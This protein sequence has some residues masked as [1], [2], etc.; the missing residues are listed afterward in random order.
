MIAEHYPLT[1]LPRLSRLFLDFCGG[2]ARSFYDV[3]ADVKRRSTNTD[4]AELVAMLSEQNPTATDSLAALREGADAVVTGQQVGLFGGPLFTIF[5]AATAIARAAQ[6]SAEGRRHVPIFWMASEDHDLAEVNHVTLPGRNELHR[7]AYSAQPS[8]AIPAGSVMFDESISALAEQ[9]GELIGTSDAQQALQA[10]YRPGRTF[11]QAFAQFYSAVFAGHGLLIFDA[12]NRTAHRLGASVLQAAIERADEL[13]AALIERNR[14]LA[15]A[16]YHAQVSV[17][18]RSSLLFLIDGNTGARLAL[19]RTAAT[20]TEPAG[21][22]QAGRESYSTADLVAILASEPERISPS[23][24]LRP[25]FQD[26][27]LPTTTYV[28]GPAEVAYFAQSAVLYERILGRT[29]PVVPRFSATIVEPSVGK[30][31]RQHQ[32]PLGTVLTESEA[33]LGQWLAV[34]SLPA[35]GRQALAAAGNALDVELA[36]LLEWMHAVDEGLGRSGE[37][38]ASK[39]RYQMNR[40]RRINANFELERE[41]TLGRHAHLIHQSLLPDGHMQERSIG[42]A[43]FLARYGSSLAQDV[44][45]YA[46]AAGH[47]LLWV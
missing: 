28:G 46:L 10:A 21:V 17:T 29:T 11:A 16:G 8:F 27:L 40:L 42:A 31:L 41:K 6:A 30:L 5:K 2:E 43:Y 18:E 26:V 14:L 1:S 19:K 15:A 23:A 7:F 9:V 4:R 34:R 36:A 32:L 38:A 39:M 37:T 20:S 33:E 44:V 35:N 12:N 25:V 24:L 3:S 45:K 13:H 47:T 22:W